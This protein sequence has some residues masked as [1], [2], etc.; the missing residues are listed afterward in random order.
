MSSK[1]RSTGNHTAGQPDNHWA[2][3]VQGHP[4]DP[5][6]R[7]NVLT[8]TQTNMMTILTQGWGR[9][10]LPLAQVPYI[11]DIAVLGRMY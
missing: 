6:V 11:L 10:G 9:A 5:A 4:C 1:G 7:S 8:N 2:V 3:S